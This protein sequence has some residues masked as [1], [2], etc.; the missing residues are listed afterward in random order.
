MLQGRQLHA[1]GEAAA[2]GWQGRACTWACTLHAGHV[3]RARAG[4]SLAGTR[5]GSQW[6]AG[7]VRFTGQ[8]PRPSL[9]TSSASHLVSTGALVPTAMTVTAAASVPSSS[10]YSHR[11]QQRGRSA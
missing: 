1:A 3:R 11:R 10:T 7:G 9:Q 2:A 6:H 4:S 5:P 8:P